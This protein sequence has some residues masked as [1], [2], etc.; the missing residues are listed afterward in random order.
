MGVAERDYQEGLVISRR[1]LL[2]KFCKVYLAKSQT[3]TKTKTD[4][5]FQRSKIKID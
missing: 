1:K 5:S 4:W 2:Q 3:H